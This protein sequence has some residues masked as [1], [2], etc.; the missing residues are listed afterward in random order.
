MFSRAALTFVLAGG[1]VTIAPVTGAQGAALEAELVATRETGATSDW[2]H[3]SPDP[4]G[5]TY[6]AETEQLLLSDGEVEETPVYEGT[7]VFVAGLDGTQQNPPGWTTVSWSIEPVGISYQSPRRILVCDDDADKVFIVDPGTDGIWTESDGAPESFST[8]PIH[9][10][11]EDVSADMDVT[12]NGH[13]L[14]VDGT[15]KTVHDYGTGPNGT[16]DGPPGTGD[17]EVLA[18]DVGQYGAQDPEGV[19]YH[20]DRNTILV[21]DALTEMIYELDRQGG[22]LNT[23]SIEAA[24]SRNAAGMTLAP[25]SDGSGATSLYI[26]DRGLDNDLNPDE[27]DGRFYEMSVDFPPL[28]SGGTGG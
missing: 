16:F 21:L 26:V 25:A 13:V 6:D 14:V 18:L 2:T 19:A 4:S 12:S 27:N 7:N 8:R 9:G 11:A 5:I 22:L 10:D 15:G 24:E 17:D 3:Q 20:P 23:F 28:R 1:A